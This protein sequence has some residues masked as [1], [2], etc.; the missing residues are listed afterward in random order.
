MANT[1]VTHDYTEVLSSGPGA[2]E[3]TQDYTEILS[4]PEDPHSKVTHDYTEV[5]SSGPWDLRVTHDYTEVLSSPSSFIVREVVPGPLYDTLG[6]GTWTVQIAERGGERVLLEAAATSVRTQGR[7]DDMAS[8]EASFAQTDVPFYCLDALSQL[9][10]WTHEL[11]LLRDGQVWGVGPIADGIS[12]TRSE[13]SVKARDLFQWFERRVF[14]R[15][16]SHTKEDLSFIFR[17]YA[18]DA[19]SRDPSPNIDIDARA[20]GV[21]GTRAVK[22]LEYA[23]AADKMRELAEIG[24]D[25]IMVG[26][27]LR[28]R[29]QGAGENVG[30]L[31][32]THCT[33][34]PR[35]SSNG[36]AAASEWILQGRT[37]TGSVPPAGVAGGVSPRIGLV[38]RKSQNTDITEH[39]DLQAGARESLAAAGTQPVRVTV[40]LDADAPIRSSDLICGN[41]LDARLSFGWKTLMEVVTIDSVAAEVTGGTETITLD[42]LRSSDA[43]A[44]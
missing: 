20:C 14:T 7:R 18:L 26:R 42:L 22:E 24:V 44:A 15:D 27:T 32:D 39:D 5:V 2:T 43:E 19:L 25:F 33:G 31:L 35:L 29:A 12:W 17:D 36:L 38:T 28:L 21:V 40:A 30:V 9:E 23:Y 13:V 4:S 11:I 3:V 1:K 10:A 41:Q 6:C 34:D 8:L 37:T 16:L